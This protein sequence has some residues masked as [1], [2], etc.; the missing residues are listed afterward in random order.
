MDTSKL[1]TLEDFIKYWK[2]CISILDD[3]NDIQVASNMVNV[4]ASNNF[5]TYYSGIRS[6]TIFAEIFD[7]IADLE[8]P[9]GP[10]YYRDAQWQMVKANLRLLEERQSK[11][12][13][14][15]QKS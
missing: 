8:L 15:R 10:Q 7:L 5:E 1:K 13:N 6:S 3:K 14:F 2:T 11:N 9:Q 12:N 4:V